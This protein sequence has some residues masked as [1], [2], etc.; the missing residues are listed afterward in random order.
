MGSV[1]SSSTVYDGQR[2]AI[3][4]LVFAAVA[5]AVVRSGREE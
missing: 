2:G 4:V 3:L 5:V 1:K